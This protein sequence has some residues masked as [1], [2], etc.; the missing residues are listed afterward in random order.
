VRVPGVAL[1]VWV[2]ATPWPAMVKEPLRLRR[3]PLA[4]TVQGAVLPEIEIDAQLTFETAEPGGQSP[5]LGVIVMLPE[6]P[7][8]PALMLLVLSP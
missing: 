7:A 4:V 6:A 5:G 2:T 1:A 3:P 8:G